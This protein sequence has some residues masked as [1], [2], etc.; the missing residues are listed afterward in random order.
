MQSVLFDTFV[1][2]IFYFISLLSLVGYGKIGALILGHRQNNSFY[3]LFFF[4]LPFLML[5][6]F[7][8]YVFIGYNFYI[9]I[10]IIILGL[11]ICLKHFGFSKSLAKQ[12]KIPLLLFL[13]LLISKTHE[14]FH[15]YHYQHLN[16]IVDGSLK[17]GMANLDG[18][19]R[20]SYSSLFS[21][22]QGF[23]Y[24]PYFELKLFHVPLYLVYVCLCCFLFEIFKKHSNKKIK[25]ISISIFI[26]LI[27]KFARLSEFGYDY[28][29]QFLLIFIIFQFFVA[30]HK[31]IHSLLA[32]ISLF[33][34]A[35]AVKI[36]AI[37]FLP[38]II[39][40][41]IK[42]KFHKVIFSKNKNIL[43]S[44]IF[45]FLILSSIFGNSFIKTG[46]IFYPIKETCFGKEEVSWLV[47]Y[48]KIE[49]HKEIAQKWAKG[50]FHTGTGAFQKENPEE[51]SE[52]IYAWVPFW[53]KNHFKNKILDFLIVL[54]LIFGLIF[55]NSKNKYFYKTNEKKYGLELVLASL[56]GLFF[57]F[58]ILPQFR[59]GFSLIILLFAG[60]IYL[61][62]GQLQK[63]DVKKINLIIII[64]IMFFN[65]KN[66]T[67]IYDS[68]NNRQDIHR[69]TNFPWFPTPKREYSSTVKFENS[70]DLFYKSSTDRIATCFN[71]PTPCAHR[72]NAIKIKKGKFIR[73]YMII[74][75]IE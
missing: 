66:V 60:L 69:Y 6:G 10:F 23:F 52:H 71:L 44:G 67:R 47:D 13:G 48:N 14:D 25:F 3:E 51:I 16:E 21:Y 39:Y 49:E 57:W 55:W 56:A 53:L 70:N 37:F 50:F 18:F 32:I 4:G 64:A 28:I 33:I 65:L 1:F 40:L 34:F 17:F 26:F 12:L 35:V 8:V 73:T 11:G 42:N 9:N 68:I 43:K 38:V 29:A 19:V 22:I 72:G 62:I 7:F 41:L 24:L 2:F 27:V 74:S 36:T 31:N 45:I 75:R 20:Y 15:L 46:C 30:N 58:S 5:L 54:L 59:F 61:F 63:F